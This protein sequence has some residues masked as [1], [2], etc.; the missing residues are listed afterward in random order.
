[1]NIFKNWTEFH[2]FYFIIIWT[3]VL[4]S[5]LKTINSTIL[6]LNIQYVNNVTV[7]LNVFLKC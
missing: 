7:V 2:A 6:L 1:M 4:Y 5:L 3:Q